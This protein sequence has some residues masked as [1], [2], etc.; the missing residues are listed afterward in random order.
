MLNKA[1]IKTIYVFVSI[2]FAILIT[3]LL[4]IKYYEDSGS[5]VSFSLVNQ[6]GVALTEKE[7]GGK[8]LLVFFGF[9]SCPDI[10]PTELSKMSQVMSQLRTSGKSHLLTP[11]FISVDPE[12]DSPEKIKRYLGYFDEQIVGLTGTRAELKRA[13][14]GFNTYFQDAPVALDDNYMVT[15]SSMLYVI[16]PFSRLIDH[17]PYGASVDLS[18]IHI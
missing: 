14:Q 7:L 3:F 8:Y 10:C 6:D 4:S 1:T 5:R 17:V 15:H 13:T 2:L 18:L 12:R 9:T 16:D 11:V